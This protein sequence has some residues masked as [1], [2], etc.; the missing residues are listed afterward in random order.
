[1]HILIANNAFYK[2]LFFYLGTANDSIERSFEESKKVFE[3]S[4]EQRA[5]EFMVRRLQ[6]WRNTEI[7]L[8]VTG[9]AGVGKSSFVNAIRG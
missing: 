4:G 8:A 2:M 9:N 5:Y 7:N 1:M 3:E 6:E